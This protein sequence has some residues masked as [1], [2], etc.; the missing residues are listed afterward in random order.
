ME[1]SGFSNSFGFNTSTN[2]FYS[3]FFYYLYVS[4]EYRQ[5]IQTETKILKMVLHGVTECTGF[6]GIVYI[7]YGLLPQKIESHISDA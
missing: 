3:F 4:D 6:L 2:F 7:D 1:S 5:H